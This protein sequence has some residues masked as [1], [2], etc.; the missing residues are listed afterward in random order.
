MAVKCAAGSLGSRER[1]IVSAARL[2][3]EYP[4]PLAVVSDGSTATVLD[5]ATGKKKGAGL[6][7]IPHR[8]EALELAR[9][10]PMPP[11]APDRLAREKLVFRSYDSMNVNVHGKGRGT[12]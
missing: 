4:M 1:E 6:P 5:T 9:R 11:I 2:F 12:I 3:S 8:T 7:S 10:N